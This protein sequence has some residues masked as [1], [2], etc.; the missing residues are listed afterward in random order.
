MKV[1]G[2]K[3]CDK[4]RAAMRALTAAGFA[5]ALVDIRAAPLEEADFKRFFDTFGEDLLN[6]RSTTWRGLDVD[7][8]ARDPVR[9]L[10]AYPALMK[11]PVIEAG[12]RLT[13]GWTSQTEV[14]WLGKP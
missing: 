2:L 13:V 3:N 6:R 10:S 9:L 4:V 14:A 12:G 8:R 11:R 5:P 1:Y 7:E